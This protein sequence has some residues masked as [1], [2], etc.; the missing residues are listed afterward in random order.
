MIEI[1]V[2]VHERESGI[3]ERLRSLGWDVT[4]RALEAGDYLLGGLIGVERKTTTDFVA[5]VTRGRLFQQL[6]QLKRVVNKP[7]LVIEGAQDGLQRLHP[8]ALQGALVSVAVA[9]SIPILWSRQPEETASFLHLIARQASM[10][11]SRHVQPSG[12]KTSKT[13]QERQVQLLNQIPRIGGRGATALLDRFGSLGGL[14]TA[15]ER[16]LQKVRGI[17]RKKAAAI[18]QLLHEPISGYRAS[19][20]HENFCVAKILRS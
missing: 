8:N 17:G 6:F 5:S 14:L 1:L 11:R 20:P 18:Y 9:W 4:E 12:L 16:D 13:K 10:R 19:K 15:S 3:A 7:L 2:D